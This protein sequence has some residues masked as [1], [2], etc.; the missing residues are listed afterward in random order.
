[1][2]PARIKMLLHK[3]DQ[4]LFKNL[5]T[6]LGKHYFSSFNGESYLRFDQEVVSL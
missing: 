3:V 6:I 5:S 1:M 2:A 4:D